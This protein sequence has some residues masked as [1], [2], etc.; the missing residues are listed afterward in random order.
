MI[1]L[2]FKVGTLLA[3]STLAFTVSAQA[4]TKKELVAKVLSLQQQGIESI[5]RS[6]AGRTAQQ[7]LGAAG[8][9][10]QR[11]PQDKQ[12]AVG[13]EVQADIKKFH[14][15]IEPI[16]RKKATEIAPA[17]L[18]ASYEEKYS[19]DELKTVIAWLES[20]VSKKFVQGEG[21]LAQA[22]VQKLVAETRPTVEPKM[23]ALEASLAKRMGLEVAPAS[24]A[25]KDPKKK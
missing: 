15:E 1:K 8:Q 14:D 2:W 19:E 23:K 20:P 12:E 24:S 4:Q 10:M 6:V 17:L 11:V 18:G 25:P 5:G 9:A 21:E 16:L 3:V 22:L 7:V 13:K